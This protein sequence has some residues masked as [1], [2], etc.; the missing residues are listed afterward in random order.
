MPAA[1]I[2]SDVQLR[3]FVAL[4]LAGFDL[5]SLLQTPTPNL[6]LAALSRRDR[7]WGLA[8][9]QRSR[10]KAHVNGISLREPRPSRPASVVTSLKG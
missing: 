5:S 6:P 9:E 3:A 7:G 2:L 8:L 1:T 10:E 4:C